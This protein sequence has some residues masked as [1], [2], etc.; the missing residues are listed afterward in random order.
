MHSRNVNT[1]YCYHTSGAK[2]QS[3]QP[4]DYAW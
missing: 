4:V 1:K 3:L 2:F